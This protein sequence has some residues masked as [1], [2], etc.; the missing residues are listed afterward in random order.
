MRSP[1]CLCQSC[2]RAF[3][4]LFLCREL[5]FENVVLKKINN[6]VSKLTF[7]HRKFLDLPL[8]QPADQ[9]AKSVIN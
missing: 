3:I 1:A 7:L 2:F 9:A 4:C 8:S 5:R 6:V